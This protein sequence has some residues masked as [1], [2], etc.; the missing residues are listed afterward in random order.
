[1]PDREG[2]AALGDGLGEGEAGAV[3]LVG[4]EGVDAR[5]IEPKP[6]NSG[7]S[8]TPTELRLEDVS[9]ATVVVDGED[10]RGLC[11]TRLEELLLGGG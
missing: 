4:V 2:I 7:T 9:V 8:S 3:C 6:A 1:M 5:F 11:P 10:M